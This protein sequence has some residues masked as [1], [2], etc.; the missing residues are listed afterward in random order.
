[1]QSAVVKVLKIDVML[2]LPAVVYPRRCT[3]ASLGSNGKPHWSCFASYIDDEGKSE[4]AQA[5]HE[6]AQTVLAKTNER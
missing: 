2:S 3:L 5:H 6:R 1:M 4:G